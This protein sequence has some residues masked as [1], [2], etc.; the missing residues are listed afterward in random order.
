L[1]KFFLCIDQCCHLL[2][3]QP[4]PCPRGLIIYCFT[5]RLRIFHFYEDVTIAIAGEEVQNLGLCTGDYIARVRIY[6][7]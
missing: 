6:H 7:I 5:S 1:L 4:D 3:D 2:A